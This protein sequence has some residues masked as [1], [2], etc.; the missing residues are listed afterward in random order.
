LFSHSARIMSSDSEV[1]DLA[2]AGREMTL[3]CSCDMC[4]EAYDND[5][6]IPRVLS[7][8]HSICQ[9]CLPQL[10]DETKKYK[11][12]TCAA[13]TLVPEAAELPVNR[14]LIDIVDFVRN[15]KPKNVGYADMNYCSHACT[16]MYIPLKDVAICTTAECN[17]ARTNICLS[18]AIRHHQKHDVVLLETVTTEIRDKCREQL[19]KLD[20]DLVTQMDDIIM[21]IQW[22]SMAKFDIRRKLLC[23]SRMA[24]LINR[25]GKLFD[26][27]ESAE[28]LGIGQDL[29]KPFSDGLSRWKTALKTMKQ[30]MKDLFALDDDGDTVG[31]QL[32]SVDE[33]EEKE[34]KE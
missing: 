32:S 16:V 9:K 24:E 15:D 20:D 27:K 8:G 23:E 7:C 18:C 10:L 6:H 26:E 11:C 14:S 29:V 31:T 25:S 28:L 3:R 13:T 33:A 2:H 22:A 19:K 21:L 34:E 12:I 17:M 30:D 5:T 4:M 1:D